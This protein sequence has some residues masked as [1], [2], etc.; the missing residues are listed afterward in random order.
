[1]LDNFPLYNI[2]EFSKERKAEFSV[3]RLP[4]EL[5]DVMG[6]AE[7]A[8]K[9]EYTE[10][11]INSDWSIVSYSDKGIMTEDVPCDTNG[12]TASDVQVYTYIPAVRELQKNR[13]WMLEAVENNGLVYSDETAGITKG[14]ALPL[15]LTSPYLFTPAFIPSIDIPGITRPKP[16]DPDA[17]KF[18]PDAA[19]ISIELF[20][21]YTSER[22]SGELETCGS[23]ASSGVIVAEITCSYNPEIPEDKEPP[24]TSEDTGNPPVA[25]EFPTGTEINVEIQVDKEDKILLYG[26]IRPDGY[27]STALY[28]T[29]GGSNIAGKNQASMKVIFNYEIQSG[30]TEGKLR[31]EASLISTKPVSEDEG[32]LIIDWEDVDIKCTKDKAS[33]LFTLSYELLN[34]RGEHISWT[35]EECSEDAGKDPSY[36]ELIFRCK[37]HKSDPNV[38]IGQNSWNGSLTLNSEASIYLGNIDSD[39]SDILSGASTRMSVALNMPTDSSPIA[40]TDLPFEYYAD[41]FDCLGGSS[42][43]KKAKI[44][45]EVV[46]SPYDFAQDSEDDRTL[47]DSCDIDIQCTCEDCT[48]EADSQFTTTLSLFERDSN[49]TLDKSRCVGMGLPGEKKDPDAFDIVTK[50][51]HTVDENCKLDFS[52]SSVVLKIV[53]DD[54]AIGV[55]PYADG[56]FYEEAMS[57]NL[58]IKEGQ[59]VNSTHKI[60]YVVAESVLSKSWRG[61]INI[62][63][64]L[65]AVDTQGKSSVI[66]LKEETIKLR[67]ACD[68]ETVDDCVNS[69]EAGI[70]MYEADGESMTDTEAKT[71]RQCC[72]EK[73]SKNSNTHLFIVP[74]AAFPNYGSE[75]LSS[76]D[77]ESKVPISGKLSIV[78]T[79][80]SISGYRGVYKGKQIV[81][82]ISGYSSLTAQH[83]EYTTPE[84]GKSGKIQ[85]D[86]NLFGEYVDENGDLQR[87][88][89][90]ERETI[91]VKC[92][93]G[94]EDPDPEKTACEILDGLKNGE[95]IDISECINGSRTISLAEGYGWLTCSSLSEMLVGSGGVQVVP[96]CDDTTP[97]VQVSLKLSGGVGIKNTITTSVALEPSEI[98]NAAGISATVSGG[99]LVLPGATVDCAGLKDM[100][101]GS[102][103]IQIGSCGTDGK[104]TINYSGGR[105]TCS[106]VKDVVTSGYLISIGGC[107]TTGKFSIGVNSSTFK[108]EV[109]NIISSW[110]SSHSTKCN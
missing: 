105:L 29:L 47:K 92:T 46:I 39:A 74:L 1:M 45:A 28:A 101:K 69:L 94:T 97:K 48:K 68:S 22:I 87:W 6:A 81:V 52:K 84:K 53:P 70:L 60:N 7:L 27:G 10:A 25:L 40:T 78:A 14:P 102:G 3:N 34:R 20:D 15:G 35:R 62:L 23:R 108:T 44:K 83:I 12:L 42:H 58:G 26:G 66:K 76:T 96:K 32:M 31:A 36:R 4:V 41:G 18:D 100:L 51:S 73:E 64:E 93:D 57:I 89:R 77:C 107:S 17:P 38:S 95:G 59:T 85:I 54:K 103:G 106:A 82:D 75:D 9:Y 21:Y 24:N 49:A 43:D 109:E 11:D 65:I 55:R 98:V 37:V 61:A 91:T 16:E 8:T 33:D 86:L 50:I 19:S 2:P 80:I 88:E 56:V 99:K 67:A 104:L 79:G 110:V 72:A 63:L 5:P 90:N 71:T 30:F 13:Q